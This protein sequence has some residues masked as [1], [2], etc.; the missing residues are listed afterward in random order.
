MKS[1]VY[2]AKST[3]ISDSALR[4]LLLCKFLEPSDL[5]RG[6]VWEQHMVLSSDHRL[7]RLVFLKELDILD[8][9]RCMF[10][11][12]NRLPVISAQPPVPLQIEWMLSF[13]ICSH[14]V[15]L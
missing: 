13:S 8:G 5:F 11:T 6:G 7:V 4:A 10:T 9:M 14:R 12:L 3:P 1:F 2:E 15:A